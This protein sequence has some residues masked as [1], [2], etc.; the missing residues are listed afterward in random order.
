MLPLRSNPITGSSS[1]LRVAPPLCPASV[2]SHLWVFHLCFSLDIR[3]TGSHV[4]HKS[5]YQV[6]A[7]SMPETIWPVI[8]F[9][10]DSS[11]GNDYPLVLTS[12]LRFRHFISWFTCVRLLDTHLTGSCP[13]FSVTLTTPAL[14]RRSLRWF[15]ASTW[16]AASR[17]QPSSL[18]QHSCTEDFVLL[19]AFVAHHH[20]HILQIAAVAHGQPSTCRMRSAGISSSTTD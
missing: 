16:M 5:L 2:L 19:C 13:A 20:Q 7:I 9:P 3:A 8:R 15:E 11:Q 10:P 12:S 14:Y 1:L 17:G 4:P 6:H 18:M